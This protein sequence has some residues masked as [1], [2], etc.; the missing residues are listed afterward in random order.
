M[1]ESHLFVVKAVVIWA[2]LSLPGNF[3]TIYFLYWNDND[4]APSTESN[5]ASPF[6]N[7]T[8]SST[9]NEQPQEITTTEKYLTTGKTLFAQKLCALLLLRTLQ[10]NPT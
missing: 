2:I 5:P 8:E 6:G 1:K 10:A 9:F 4:V 7:F 3:A